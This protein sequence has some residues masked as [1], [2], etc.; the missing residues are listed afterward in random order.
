[1]PNPANIKICEDYSPLELLKAVEY[2][3]EDKFHL[4]V[5]NVVDKKYKESE[6]KRE[7]YDQYRWVMCGCFF[8]F[9]ASIGRNILYRL[10]EIFVK[11]TNQGYG[12]A[13]EMFYLEILDEYRDDLA[14]T[15]GDY[16]QIVNNWMGPKRNIHY[17]FHLIL[18]GYSNKGYFEEAISCGRQLIDAFRRHDIPRDDVM[19]LEIAEIVYMSYMGLDA[20]D[21]AKE[22]M[23]GFLYEC[24]FDPF[25]NK[26]ALY[27][28]LR[29]QFNEFLCI[30]D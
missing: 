12:H 30:M 16:G 8:T 11:T 1:M 23:E 6:H 14:I 4:Q 17:I 2:T 19:Y 9:G 3:K 24:M 15:Y 5:L 18:R 13:E 27:E 29:D 26:S 20:V 10:C 25:L 28:T 7:F 22:F 21:P